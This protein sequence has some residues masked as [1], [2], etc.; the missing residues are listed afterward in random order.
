MCMETTYPPNTDKQETEKFGHGKRQTL[1]VANYKACKKK[2][3]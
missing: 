1:V 2:I 3:N